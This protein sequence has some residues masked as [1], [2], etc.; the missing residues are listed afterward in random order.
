M[1][2]GSIFKFLDQRLFGTSSNRHLFIKE[3]DNLQGILG[4]LVNGHVT[5]D[6]GDQFNVNSDVISCHWSN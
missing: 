2:S 1:N 5:S 6:T 3:A 4:C